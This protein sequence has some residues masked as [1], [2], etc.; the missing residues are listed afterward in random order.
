MKELKPFEN[1]LI[2]EFVDDYI[3]GY[4]TRREMIKRVLPSW[5]GWP[6]QPPF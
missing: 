2:H 4:L 1:D 6:R 5:S 3:D